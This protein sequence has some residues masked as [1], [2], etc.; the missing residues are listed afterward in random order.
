MDIKE[1]IWYGLANF[2]LEIADYLHDI[3]VIED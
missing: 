2:F 1:D 3:C